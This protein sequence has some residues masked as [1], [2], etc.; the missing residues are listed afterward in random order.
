M[1][2]SAR[3]PTREG[4]FQLA[5]Y[6]NP[7]DEK[8]HLALIY[9]EL[10][11]ASDVLVRV[12]SECFTGDV[13]GSLRCDCGEQLHASM[14]MIAEEGT[15]VI[16]YL[17]QEGRGIG[18]LSKLRAYNLQDEGYDTVEANLALGHGADERD[19][20]IG[21][22]ILKDLGLDS[23][24]L[25]TNNPEKIESLEALGISVSARVPLE[26][27]LNEH[28][29]EYLQT[30]VQ[31]MRHMLELAPPAEAP[32]RVDRTMSA[33]LARR[34]SD[35]A[36]DQPFVTLSYTH[37]L[38]G[39]ILL[40]HTPRTSPGPAPIPSA[41]QQLLSTHDALLVGADSLLKHDD[42]AP[43]LAPQR[44]PRLIVLETA[45]NAQPV[46]ARLRALDAPSILVTTAPPPDP[47]ATA[48]EKL[49][50]LQLPAEYGN[51]PDEL[52]GALLQRLH[53]AG[54]ESLAVIGPLTLIAELMRQQRANHVAI[55]M[56]PMY[57]ETPASFEVLVQPGG[58]NGPLATPTP[59]LT[60]RSYQW[61]G[62]NLIV[63]GDPVWDD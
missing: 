11:D 53:A 30:K 46:A 35:H 38:S 29:T 56:A 48:T 40:H 39:P 57:T 34:M 1:L 17:R 22:L 10:D 44:R 19:Y 63:R 6:A 42:L 62:A 9:G 28:N 25:I 60:N 13:L 37:T 2:T 20:T 51:Q 50:W 59:Q 52:I 49:T 26:P 36:A 45:Q 55:T 5:F 3:I 43:Q 27:H 8:D 12:H 14:R 31:R 33:S 54:V 18:L 15:G 24:R 47:A 41:I 61:A 58:Q 4:T 16:L 21:A 7:Q 32:H 23:V